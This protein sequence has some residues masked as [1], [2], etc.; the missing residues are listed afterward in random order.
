ML[1]FFSC[2]ICSQYSHSIH[3]VSPLCT[4]NYFSYFSSPGMKQQ[5]LYY[6]FCFVQVPLMVLQLQTRLMAF[7]ESAVSSS[8]SSAQCFDITPASRRAVPRFC[9]FTKHISKSF[10]KSNLMCFSVVFI[11]CLM[12]TDSLYIHTVK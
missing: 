11:G 6:R 7:L 5:R 12:S 2:D 8:L 4:L 3:F 9:D 10:T 1:A